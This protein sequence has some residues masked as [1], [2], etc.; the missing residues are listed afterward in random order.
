MQPQ[1]ENMTFFSYA[2]AMKIVPHTTNSYAFA[3]KIVPHTTNSL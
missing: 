3:K 1:R 2:F